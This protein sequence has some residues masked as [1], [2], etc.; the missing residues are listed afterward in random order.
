MADQK[1]YLL[2]GVR[3]IAALFVVTRHTPDIWGRLD[4]VESYLAVDLF[5]ALSGF[6]I[7]KSYEAKLSSGHLSITDFL[8]KRFIRLYPLYFLGAVLM[9]FLYAA[10]PIFSMVSMGRSAS[11]LDYVSLFLMLP[12]VSTS[13]LFPINGPAWSLFLEL[14]V[15]EIFAL[16]LVTKK[17]RRPIEVILVVASGVLLVVS[18]NTFG[19]LEDGYTW[20]RAGVGFVRTVYSFYM[21]VFAYR[22]SQTTLAVPS[23]PSVVALLFIAGVLAFPVPE[24]ARRY[25]DCLFVLAIFPVL[26][27]VASFATPSKAEIRVLRFLGVIS[28]PIYIL[29]VPLYYFF[30]IATGAFWG[31]FP[32]SIPLVGMAFLLLVCATIVSLVQRYETPVRRWAEVTFIKSNNVHTAPRTRITE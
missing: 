21:G 27:Y 31:L 29:H 14:V 24:A 8:K 6:V 23:I 2:D 20:N 4:F 16:L 12:N 26:V 3:G 5:F 32:K 9:S 30:F 17:V 19:A 10:I 22:L 18:A 15:N 11:W 13:Q 25:Y 28:Y 7:A 1:Y